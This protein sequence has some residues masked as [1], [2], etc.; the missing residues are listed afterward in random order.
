MNFM[1]KINDL[2]Y[3][4]FNCMKLNYLIVLNKQ[5]NY[6]KNIN[7]VTIVQIRIKLQFTHFSLCYENK[8][9]QKFATCSS[10]IHLKRIT[11]GMDLKNKGW[12]YFTV[13]Y[14]PNRYIFLC[15]FDNQVTCS[16]CNL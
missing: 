16:N 6:N 12:L 1:E 14:I 3:R 4:S 15:F 2:F 7:V 11:F 13:L 5:I 9:S 8:P 10:L